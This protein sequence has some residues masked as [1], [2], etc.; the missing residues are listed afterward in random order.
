MLH[1]HLLGDFLE[2]FNARR[3]IHEVLLGKQNVDNDVITSLKIQGGVHTDQEEGITDKYFFYIE[4]HSILDI[5]CILMGKGNHPLR[6]MK[7]WL[8]Q[9][10]P[11]ARPPLTT[12]GLLMCIASLLTFCSHLLT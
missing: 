10:P 12:V 11:G 7:W 1:S 4:N 2:Y 8:V 3:K 9:E 5:G 6:K